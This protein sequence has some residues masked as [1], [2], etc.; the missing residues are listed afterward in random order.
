MSLAALS[1]NQGDRPSN[2]LVV[3][4]A[5]HDL[6]EAAQTVFGETNVCRRNGRKPWAHAVV[7]T[8]GPTSSSCLHSFQ[9]RNAFPQGHINK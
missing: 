2:G 6:L 3:H 4:V 7:A 9:L 5:L 8:I 1:R